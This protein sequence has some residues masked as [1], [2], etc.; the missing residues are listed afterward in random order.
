MSDNFLQ[1]D[2]VG[3]GAI[4]ASSLFVGQ[5]PDVQVLLDDLGVKM[6]AIPN[7]VDDRGSLSFFELDSGL[8]FDPQ[9]I[10]TISNVPVGKKRGE[11]AHYK[12]QQILVCLNGSCEIE[13]DSGTLKLKIVLDS[14][15]VGIYFPPLLWATLNLKNQFTT[16]L[17]LAS[18]KYDELDYI[19]DYEA[20][21]KMKASIK[22]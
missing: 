5:N 6:I 7:R 19:R 14:P 1:S 9:R 16:V 3:K 15:T 4:K 8:P 11:H 22:E 21:L 17:A 12:C 13:I 18:L 10:F 2:F 20:F